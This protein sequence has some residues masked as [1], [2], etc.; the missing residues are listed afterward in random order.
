M[1]EEAV[2]KKPSTMLSTKKT[3]L[4]FKVIHLPSLKLVLTCFWHKPTPGNRW[5]RFPGMA[6]GAF[7][8]L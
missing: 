5:R 1:R 3:V 4:L 2:N 8:L 6:C 7:H